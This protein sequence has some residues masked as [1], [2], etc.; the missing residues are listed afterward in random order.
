MCN[1]RN[2]TDEHM[3]RGKKREREA[4]H[5]RLLTVENKLRVN[6]GRWVGDGLNGSWALKRAIVGMNTGCCM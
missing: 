5:K 1:L 3:G 4:N 2:K 6:G